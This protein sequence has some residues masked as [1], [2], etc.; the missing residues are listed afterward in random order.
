[1]LPQILLNAAVINPELGPNDYIGWILWLVGFI[2]ETLADAQKY[3]YKADPKNKGHWCDAGIWKA[4]RFDQAII[5]VG[6]D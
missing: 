3:Q 2:S 6:I 1:M 4:S 5:E